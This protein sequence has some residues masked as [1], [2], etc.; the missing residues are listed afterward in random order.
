MAWYRETGRAREGCFQDMTLP[1][2]GEES[3]AKQK[4]QGH[5]LGEKNMQRHENWDLKI[6]QY[7]N[8]SLYLTT[9]CMRKV[10]T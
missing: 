5:R 6:V 8:H 2:K 1:L 10:G 3:F 4:E 7:V 9:K